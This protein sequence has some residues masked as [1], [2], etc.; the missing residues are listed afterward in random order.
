[1]KPTLAVL[2]PILILAL[3]STDRATAQGGHTLA[4]KLT[5]RDA[6]HDPDGVWT[7][8]DLASIRQLTGQAKIYTARIT[9]PSG[10]WLLSQTNGDCN[11]QGMCTALLVLIRPD[12]QSPRPVRPV[13]PERMANP[14]MP[15]GGTAVLSPD[16]ATLTTAE[17][18]EDGKAF[19]GIYQ[20]EPIR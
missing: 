1:M 2:A 11:L 16:A 19:I 12:T 6:K 13:R 7:D 17:I 14:Q 4:L 20:V 15:L 8:D 18:G 3:T 9:T 5:T 10:T